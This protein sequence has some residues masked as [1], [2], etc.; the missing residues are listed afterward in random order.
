MARKEDSGF[1]EGREVRP[2]FDA[3]GADVPDGGGEPR[4]RLEGGHGGEEVG[5][6]FVVAGVEVI[7]LTLK[8]EP[9]QV[10]MKCVCELLRSLREAIFQRRT[11]SVS[12][13]GIEGYGT[14]WLCGYGAGAPKKAIQSLRALGHGSGLQPS[15]SI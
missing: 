7:L 4:E 13:R 12:V 11:N 3:E 5:E 2:L 1:D 15:R 9:S 14:T 6:V 10:L 8:A